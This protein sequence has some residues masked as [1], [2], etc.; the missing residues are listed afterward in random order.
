MTIQGFAL[1]DTAI[2]RC[3]IAWSGRGVAGVRLPEV[4][5]PAMRARMRRW[6]PD[7]REGAPPPDVERAVD[8]ITA[9]LRGEASALAAVV[10]D[11]DGIPAFDRGVYTAAR[12]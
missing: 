7:A 3:G 1:F 4:R 11:M 12:G 2:G 9:L 10:L 6:F 8:S 5:E